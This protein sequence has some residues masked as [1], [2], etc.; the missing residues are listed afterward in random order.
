MAF[1][2]EIGLKRGVRDARGRAVVSKARQFLRL[3]VRSCQTRD[4]YKVDVALSRAELRR[5]R[6]AF[7]DP[8]IARAAVGRLAPPS[9][10]W[11]VEVGFKP[12]VT[13]NVGHTARDV[14]R[15][16]LERELSHD[17]SVYTSIQYLLRGPDLSRDDA[18]RLGRDLLANPLIHSIQVFS[19]A[20]W[21]SAPI[22]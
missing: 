8:V 22:D 3:P 1:R 6:D 16:V 15:D 12:G 5:V 10:Q 19:A 17:Q 20:D 7:T 2:M 9:F 18:W 21:A 14:L 11:M 13:D 4:V